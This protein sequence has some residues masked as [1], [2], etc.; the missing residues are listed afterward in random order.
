MKGWHGAGALCKGKTTF[1]QITSLVVI[2]NFQTS[3]LKI[4]LLGEAETA[5]SLV[6]KS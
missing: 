2:R 3:W 5:I 4:L 6:I 1:P